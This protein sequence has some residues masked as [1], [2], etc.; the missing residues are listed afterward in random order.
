MKLLEIL[1]NDISLDDL[2]NFDNSFAIEHEKSRL[3]KYKLKGK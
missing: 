2:L 3:K 1:L